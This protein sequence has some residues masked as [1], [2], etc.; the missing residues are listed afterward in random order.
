MKVSITIPDEGLIT[1]VKVDGRE[2]VL[3]PPVAIKKGDKVIDLTGVRRQA[4]E[5]VERMGDQRHRDFIESE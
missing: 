1:S 2:V 3:D 4:E 5:D